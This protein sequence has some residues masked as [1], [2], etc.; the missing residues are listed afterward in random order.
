MIGIFAGSYLFSAI[1]DT[2]AIQRIYKLKEDSD[3]ADIRKILYREAFN[4]FADSPFIGKGLDNF[5]LFSASGL[6]AHSNYL[7][8]LADTGIIGFILFYMVYIMVWRNSSQLKYY[9]ES[10]D[11]AKLL[12]GIFKCIIILFLIVGLGSVQY[13]SI[14]HWILLIFPIVV[15][16]QLV[17]RDRELEALEEVP[18]KADLDFKM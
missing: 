16:E 9:D 14:T 1:S 17:L 6:Y 10:S 8:L 7:E 3:G 11:H 18:L 2:A 15:Y 5:R 12:S 13:D 4:V